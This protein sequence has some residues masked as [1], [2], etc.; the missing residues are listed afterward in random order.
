MEK[1]KEEFNLF[2]RE[3]MS[4][5]NSDASVQLYQFLLGCFVRADEDLEGRVKLANFDSL[6]AEAAELPR[7][8]GYAPTK[9]E[10]YPKDDGA[11]EKARAKTFAQINNKDQDYIT[12]EQWLKFSMK[13]IKM[14]VK[15]LPKAVMTGEGVSKKE[16]LE[17]VEKAV[18]KTSPEF[19]E[20][21]FFLLKC[22][23]DA[24]RDHDGSVNAAEFDTMIEVAA[25]APRKYGLAPQS[26]KMYKNVAERLERRTEQFKEMDLNDNGKISFDEWLSYSVDHIIGKVNAMHLTSKR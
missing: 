20:L 24:D 12:L 22:F 19:R 13:H 14:K 25:S 18:D 2:I 4:E 11:C 1:T 9:E 10:M 3:A 6:I 21:Y 7:K 23:V 16:F 17:L 15:T 8:Y 26:K 5:P